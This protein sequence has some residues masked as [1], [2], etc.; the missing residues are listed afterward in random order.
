MLFT[1]IDSTPVLVA[2]G[3]NSA[4]N[5]AEGFGDLTLGAAYTFAPAGVGLELELSG[6]AKLNTASRSSKLSSGELDYAIGGQITKPLGDFG[7]FVS[8]TYRVLGDT[9]TYRLRNG[10]AA[11]AGTSL[12]IGSRT[13][14]LASYHYS[15][16]ATDF[17]KDAHEVFAGAVTALPNSRLRFSGFGTL[18]LSRGAAA[19]SA[20]LALSSDF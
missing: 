5:T 7:P 11:S 8:A 13:Y 18:G 2:P 9:A 1:G 19:A 12:A 15:E 14:L 10:L 6:R 4:R 16:R 17:V 3:A 20:G